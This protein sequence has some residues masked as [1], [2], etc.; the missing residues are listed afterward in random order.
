MTAGVVSSLM[1]LR[2]KASADQDASVRI[3][4]SQANEVYPQHFAQKRGVRKDF[5]L[6]LEVLIRLRT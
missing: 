6:S 2:T 3:D 4:F 1:A 5:F